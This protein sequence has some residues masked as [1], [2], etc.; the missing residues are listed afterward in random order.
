MLIIYRI[1]QLLVAYPLIILATALT[2]LV[3][4]V[5]CFLGNGHVWGY[6]PGKCWSWFVIRILLLPIKVEGRENLQPGQSYVFA[7]NHQGAFDIFMIYGFLG[8]NF[9]WMMKQSLRKIPLVGKACEAAHHI[10]VDKRSA[11]KIKK[12]IDEA[13]QTLKNGMSL[14]IFPEGARTFTGHMGLFRRGA[15][16]LA[17]ELQ[18]PVVPITINGSFDVMPRMRDFHFAHFAPLHLT[19]HAPIHPT[20]QGHENI[21]RLLD[22]SYQTIMDGLPEERRGYIK[23]DDQ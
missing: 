19:I 9:K 4:I 14:V 15:F 23:N 3:T 13:R 6:Y 22:E 16:Q 17:D 1:Y 7:A 18:L 8:S 5:G 20:S 21:K 10:F 2:A 11:S 12:T